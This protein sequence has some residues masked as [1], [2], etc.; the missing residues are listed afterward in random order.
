MTDF[1]FQRAAEQIPQGYSA[2]DKLREA[3]SDRADFQ[4]EQAELPA[5]TYYDGQGRIK[6]LGANNSYRA[7]SIQS[8]APLGVG[9]R[10]AEQGGLVQA[11]PRSG[12]SNQLAR[13]M[14]S[15][16]TR[17]NRILRGLLIEDYDVVVDTGN[18]TY[19]LITSSSV[20]YT[21]LAITASGTGTGALSPTVGGEIAVGGTLD[22]TLSGN[23]DT[24][25]SA[26]IRL[27]RRL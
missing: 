1:D 27:R 20:R 5:P 8:N 3:Q 25:W 2:R 15:A 22:L 10:V 19:P 16:F 7:R 9:D 18:D 12:N 23:D 17:I 21:V 14:T 24:R 13:F 6:P 26:T 4:L 11:T